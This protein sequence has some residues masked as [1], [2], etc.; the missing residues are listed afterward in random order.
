MADEF[1]KRNITGR[2][3]ERSDHYFTR[4]SNIIDQVGTRGGFKVYSMKHPTRATTLILR[5]MH[6]LTTVAVPYKYVVDPSKVPPNYYPPEIGRFLQNNRLWLNRVFLYDSTITT[7]DRA[8]AGTSGLNTSQGSSTNSTNK[9]SNLNVSTKSTKPLLTPAK[10][11]PKFK[12]KPIAKVRPFK[13]ITPKV[14]FRT[15]K[16]APKLSTAAKLANTSSGVGP[17]MDARAQMEMHVMNQDLFG[18]AFF[19]FPENESTDAPQTPLTLDEYM[20]QF[21]LNIINS[22]FLIEPALYK[23]Q[24]PAETNMRGYQKVYNLWQE[25]AKTVMYLIEENS[26]TLR[27]EAIDNLNTQIELTLAHVSLGDWRETL[28]LINTEWERFT[29]TVNDFYARQ[30][31]ADVE[32]DKEFIDE[33]LKHQGKCPNVNNIMQNYIKLSRNMESRYPNIQVVL[34]ICFFILALSGIIGIIALISMKFLHGT[35]DL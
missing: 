13:M 25:M 32:D 34:F 6:R 22:D 27:V 21:I 19:L 5:D 29:A 20:H 10:R 9:P 31:E 2:S 3:N 26:P 8:A 33:I 18:P 7:T 23:A 4:Y 1:Y 17:S 14:K 35:I 24:N 11:A 16:S 30:A 28:E 12:S 15:L